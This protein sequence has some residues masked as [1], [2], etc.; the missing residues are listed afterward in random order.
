M[1]SDIKIHVICHCVGSIG[2]MTSLASNQVSGIQSVISNSVSLTPKVRWQ[3]F[4]KLVFGPFFLEYIFRYHY[5]GPKIPYFPG[6]GSGKW[7]YWMERLLRR[8]C[9]EPACHM[10]SFMWGWGFPAAYKHENLH[11]VTHR[12]LMDLF[13]GTSYHYYRHIRKMLFAKEAIPY[14]KKLDKQNLPDS[15]LQ[16]VRNVK[17]PPLLLISGSENHIFPGAN[18]I[19]AQKIRELLP[20]ANVEFVEIPGYGHQDVFM[21]KKVH[22]DVFPKLLQ[23]L[24]QHS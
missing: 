11:P 5:V 8:E 1:G 20:D 22:V 19:T 3:S 23:F 21:G 13:G 15:Y 18:K 9:R 14:D 7:I 10:V 24:K 4:L 12:R 16:N 17:L 6:F 2:F